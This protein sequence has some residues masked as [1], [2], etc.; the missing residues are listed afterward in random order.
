MASTVGEVK[1]NKRVIL[2]NYVTGLPKESDM[3][4][5]TAEA[6]RLRVPYGSKAVLL[7]NLYLS[8]DPYMKFLMTKKEEPFLI[9]DYVPGSVYLH[10]ILCYVPVHKLCF[11]VQGSWQWSSI[12]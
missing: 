6:A 9:P 11:F 2:K 3:E 1:P 12:I 7:K 10:S 8:C 4:I 5:V